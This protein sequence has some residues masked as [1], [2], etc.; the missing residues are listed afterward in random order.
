M[1]TFPKIDVDLWKQLRLHPC[2]L[3]SKIWNNYFELITS[4]QIVDQ[5]DN[6]T[7]IKQKHELAIRDHLNI[8]YTL[9][10]HPYYAAPEEAQICEQLFNLDVYSIDTLDPY[11]EIFADFQKNKPLPEITE[12]YAT[13]EISNSN[14][15][16]VLQ[17][18]YDTPEGRW[19]EDLWWKLRENP[20]FETM[21]QEATRI[22]VNFAIEHN[23]VTKAVFY[24]MVNTVSLTDYP[25]YVYMEFGEP[26]GMS[27]CKTMHQITVQSDDQSI[28]YIQP[29]TAQCDAYFPL[30][31]R[32][33]HAIEHAREN[34]ET[35][36]DIQSLYKELQLIEVHDIEL[37]LEFL[38][39]LQLFGKETECEELFNTLTE[40]DIAM[41][42]Q[43]SASTSHDILQKKL[44]H[45][46]NTQDIEHTKHILE[47]YSFNGTFAPDD[48]KH[49]FILKNLNEN[50]KVGDAL[51]VYRSLIQNNPAEYSHTL[52]Y[53]DACRRTI[54]SDDTSLKE[55][56]L[57]HY[58]LDNF[59][60][61]INI[62]KTPDFFLY[63][64]I[65]NEIS[66]CFSKCNEI[67]NY[68]KNLIALAEVLSLTPSRG[69]T[70]LTEHLFNT[71]VLAPKDYLEKFILPYTADILKLITWEI[72]TLGFY[73][74]FYYEYYQITPTYQ[75]EL[76]GD[77]HLSPISDAQD[78]LQYKIEKFDSEFHPAF[79][80]YF[81]KIQTLQDQPSEKEAQ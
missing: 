61:A 60:E 11:D 80:F 10:C 2:S 48:F 21:D 13:I 43:F 78:T 27:F 81:K 32:F 59:A 33:L 70:I 53:F 50:R 55:K 9:M 66:T 16:E 36:E 6:L 12:H 74:N 22:L 69:L 77:F 76:P 57:A 39:Y 1:S 8:P 23:C 54:A 37:K 63:S 3:P 42:L 30:R 47:H 62:A 51:L 49:K 45:F 72:D 52:D 46:T 75:Q 64:D 24:T 40:L 56:F 28:K 20:F 25:R 4:A 41:L 19:N 17:E 79:V 18:L 65:A 7:E 44:E 58:D 15:E 67:E 34:N 38:K 35:L 5:V 26:A 31:R 71:P 29:N 68:W 14:F 73:I